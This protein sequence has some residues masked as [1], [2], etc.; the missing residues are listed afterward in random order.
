MDKR[1]FQDIAQAFKDAEPAFIAA[2][3]KPIAMIDRYRGQP[4]NPEQFEYYP[5][6]A[7][8]IQRGTKWER[9]GRHYNAKMK[10]QFHIVSDPTWDT[11]SIATNR[12]EGLQYFSFLDQVRYVIDNFKSIY[13]GTMFR[14]EDDDVDSGVVFY[15]VLSYQCDYYGN[16]DLK[17][18][19]E[20]NYDADTMAIITSRKATIR[21]A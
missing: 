18:Q 21:E 9:V 17:P 14:D 3:V 4:M 19:Y 12:D 11:S 8:F 10:L 16:S 7:I 13:T 2:G 1:F 5:L 20:S 15:D 6:P